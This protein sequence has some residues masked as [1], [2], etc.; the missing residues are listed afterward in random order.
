MLDIFLREYN[1][2]LQNQICCVILVLAVHFQM[3][4]DGLYVG[5][6]TA[7]VGYD[8]IHRHRYCHETSCMERLIDTSCRYFIN[9]SWDDGVI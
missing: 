9:I 6:P 7:V 5:T 1:S 2:S 4:C 8:A 3:E